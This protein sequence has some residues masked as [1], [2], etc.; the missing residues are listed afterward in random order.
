MHITYTYLVCTLCYIE[1]PCSL[2][3]YATMNCTA[4]NDIEISAKSHSL[5]YQYFCSGVAGS[6]CT[7][8]CVLLIVHS[9]SAVL[10][11]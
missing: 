4:G 11:Q 10:S 6:L 2:Y 8:V 1:V 7:T 5:L 3:D 9:D